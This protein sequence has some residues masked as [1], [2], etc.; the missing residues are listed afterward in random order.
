MAKGDKKPKRVAAGAMTP[1]QLK[2]FEANLALQQ[3]AADMAEAQLKREE[4]SAQRA[5]QYDSLGKMAQMYRDRSAAV[6]TQY[7]DRV[8]QVGLDR[9]AALQGYDDYSG[10]VGSQ[11]EAALQQLLGAANTS[12]GQIGSAQEQ[13]LKSLI[14]TSAYR[15]APLVELGQIDNPL[16]AGLRAEGASTAGVEQQSGQDA[17]IAAQLAA[18]TRG[19]MAQLNVGEQNYLNA[20]RNEGEQSAAGARTSLAGTE[21]QGRQ[22]INSE[23]DDLI[24]QIAA[25]RQAAGSDYDSQISDLGLKRLGETSDYDSRA[26]EAAGQQQGFA[27]IK[28]DDYATRLEAARQAALQSINRSLPTISVNNKS[29]PP[30][31]VA[32]GKIGQSLGKVTVPYQNLPKGAQ[33]TPAQIK[34]KREMEDYLAIQKRGL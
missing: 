13:F 2:V 8:K 9:V 29:A 17:Q 34:R 12:R 16:L 15:D 33:L 18:L 10:Q 22:G 20:L 27:P 7:D 4:E 6:G 26:L 30:A 1:A 19:S 28:S 24:R 5:A 32:T 11:R 21:F 3:R 25:Q 31:V 14:S 23:Y